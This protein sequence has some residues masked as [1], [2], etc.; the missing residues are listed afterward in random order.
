MTPERWKQIEKIFFEAADLPI[1]ERILFLEE[2]CINDPELKQEVESLLRQEDGTETILKTLISNAVESLPQNEITDLTGT[3]IGAYRITGLIGQGGMAQVYKATRDDDQYQKIVAIKIIRQ[4]VVPSLLIH[5]FWYERQIL[6]NLEHPYIARFLEGGTTEDRIP[7]F[8]MEYIEGEPITAYC[9]KH[10]LTIQKRLELFRQ[11]C[12][13]VQ[14]AHRNLVIH[15]DL[16]PSNI[17]VTSEGIPKLLDFG[18]A[19]FLNPELSAAIPTTTLTSICLMTPEYAS[20]EQVRGQPVTTATDIY[21]LG[22][23]LYELLTSQRAQQFRTKSIAE[24]ERVVCERQ[25]EAPSSI[26]TSSAST[27]TK[28]GMK[29]SNPKKLSRKLAREVDSIVL[30]AIH[31]DPQN[32]YRTA[33]EFSDDISRYMDGLPIRARTQ[34]WGYRAIKFVRR[35]KT[36]VASASIIALL[37]AGLAAVMT[38]QASRIAKERDRANKVTEFLVD[39]FEVSD[40]DE[41]RGNT[42]TARE[43]LD[44]SAKKIERELGEQPEVQA[45]LMN[46]MGRVY[47]NLGLS[48]TSVTLFEKAL[49]IRKREL[50]EENVE[51]ASTMD[52]LSS[53]LS[54][55]GRYSEAEAI[56]RKS[57][58]IRRKL[59]GNEHTD[60][61]V[62]LDTLAVSLFL[63]GKYDEA[64]AAL[65]EALT[66]HQKVTGEESI[67]VAWSLN[68]LANVLR[69][70][71]KDKEAEPLYRQSLAICRNLFGNNHRET[72]NSM[73][74]L[75]RLLL[76]NADYDGAE[77]L[78][79]EALDLSRKVLGENHPDLANAMW[80]LALVMRAKKRYTDAE[81]LL[82]DGL[83]LRRKSLGNQHPKVATHLYTLGVLL[84]DKGDFDEAES[85]LSEAGLLWQKTLPPNHDNHANIF[86][87]LGHVRMQKGNPKEAETQFRKALEIRVRALPADHP[88]LANLKVSLGDCLTAQGRYKE[89]ESILVDSY[90]T[91]TVKQGMKHPDSVKAAKTLA[92]LYTAWGKPNEAA[93]YQ[94]K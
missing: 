70:K 13:A 53:A 26:V 73:K 45:A 6:A 9:D 93:K 34:T 58:I 25:P 60:V 84:V 72:L 16:K 85:L 46:T 92:S 49:Q 76:D 89:A 3:R 14:Y 21:S 71:G 81:T 69:F 36:A 74:N 23:L 19:K 37:L 2:S 43:L 51:I 91:L 10:G 33:V 47:Q 94:T 65:R 75:G 24:I 80:N 54:D 50:G 83:I 1:Q 87:M 67:E 8:V 44:A 88:R 11:V 55:A 59:H 52:D 90:R 63:N 38:I 68:N 82:R 64:E 79:S 28:I 30:M 12:D 56:A 41:T 18:I 39:L 77:V 42:V 66:I 48:H 22:L 15:R 62:S 31:K 27:T 78:F 17:M 20:P 32:R 4:D 40:P 35:H 7:Y 57:L 86:W 61:A 5:R 29:K